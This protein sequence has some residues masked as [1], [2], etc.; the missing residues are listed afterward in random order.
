MSAALVHVTI[1]LERIDSSIMMPRPR[2][3]NET[4]SPAV[5]TFVTLRRRGVDVSEAEFATSLART[6]LAVQ[7]QFRPTQYFVLNRG[8]STRWF[9]CYRRH[10][11]GY[12][13]VILSR[14]WRLHEGQVEDVP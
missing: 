3:S 6:L 8:R 11:G 1:A 2:E 10:A 5:E 14:T 4:D 13:R 9:R 12:E 7:P